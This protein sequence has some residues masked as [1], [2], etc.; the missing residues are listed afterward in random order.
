MILTKKSRHEQVYVETDHVLFCVSK[1]IRN[2]VSY[3]F[4][5]ATL[6]HKINIYDSLLFRICFTICLLH[7][8]FL[9]DLLFPQLFELVL[10]RTVLFKHTVEN[11][12]SQ[13]N[14]TIISDIPNQFLQFLLDAVL[15]FK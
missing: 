4:D 12:Q 13:S 3:L 7:Q 11:K 5:A 6:F 9:H 14:R 8:F 2:R 15:D 1:K 10:T